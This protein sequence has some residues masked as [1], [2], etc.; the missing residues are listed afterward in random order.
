MIRIT[1]D[2]D[3]TFGKLGEM[4]GSLRPGLRHSA[5]VA[6][7][8]M[9]TSSSSNFRLPSIHDQSPCPQT[10]K[11]RTLRRLSISRSTKSVK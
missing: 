1:I 7:T 6:N 11:R 3:D 2:K 10:R 8:N 9:A 5:P 4:V